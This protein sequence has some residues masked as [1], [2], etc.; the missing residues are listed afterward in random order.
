M[1]DFKVSDTRLFPGKPITA[2]I[3][4]EF[5]ATQGH[6]AKRTSDRANDVRTRGSN[7]QTYPKTDKGYHVVAETDFQ[8]GHHHDTG[9]FK[10]SFTGS[11]LHIKTGYYDVICFASWNHHTV[12]SGGTDVGASLQIRSLN[13]DGSYAGDFAMCHKNGPHYEGSYNPNLRWYSTASAYTA[14]NASVTQGVYMGGNYRIAL[15]TVSSQTRTVQC[16]G[17]IQICQRKEISTC[18]I[19]CERGQYDEDTGELEVDSSFGVTTLSSTESAGKVI[20]PMKIYWS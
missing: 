1:A 20:E 15:Q 5:D 13:D 7:G 12:D 9:F 2:Q 18:P 19:S 16:A 3:I 11:V 4:Q 6:I 10:E 14:N 8:I 17:Y